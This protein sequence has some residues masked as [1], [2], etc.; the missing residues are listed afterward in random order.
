MTPVEQAREADAKAEAAFL[1]GR[2]DRH[3]RGLSGRNWLIPSHED[4]RC[5]DTSPGAW[6]FSEW[7]NAA[8]MI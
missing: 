7:G 5:W 8:G 1:T 2:G 6:R 4:M 3:P